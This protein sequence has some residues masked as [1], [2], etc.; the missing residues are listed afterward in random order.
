MADFAY[1]EANIENPEANMKIYRQIL[2]WIAAIASIATAVDYF[3]L[4]STVRKAFKLPEV[5]STSVVLMVLGPMSILTIGALA[6]A[7]HFWISKIRT[8][9]KNHLLKKKQDD[10]FKRHT[11]TLNELNKLKDKLNPHNDPNN[12]LKTRIRGILKAGPL[13][14]PKLLHSLDLANFESDRQLLSKILGEMD[15]ISAENEKYL[16]RESIT[17]SQS[18]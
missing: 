10:E 16:L 1:Q 5:I 13:N 8:Q 18:D 17:K 2:N 3:F 4:N 9:E 7:A 11:E 14:F 6:L 12:N 15:D